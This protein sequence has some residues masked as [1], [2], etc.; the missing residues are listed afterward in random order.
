[1]VMK[2]KMFLKVNKIG[3]ITTLCLLKCRSFSQINYLS[4]VFF[5]ASFEPCNWTSKCSEK[6]FIRNCIIKL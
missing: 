4:H 5:L 2:K 6:E 1:M 3:F